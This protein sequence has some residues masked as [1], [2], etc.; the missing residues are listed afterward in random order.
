MSFGNVGVV[1]S[2]SRCTVDEP[3]LAHRLTTAESKSYSQRITPTLSG[4]Q[5]GHTIPAVRS[6]PVLG[7][8]F[9]GAILSILSPARRWRF[10]GDRQVSCVD[11]NDLLYLDADLDDDG[12][13]FQLVL[14]C[15]CVCCYGKRN[16]AAIPVAWPTLLSLSER[17]REVSGKKCTLQYAKPR[18]KKHVDVLPTSD[19]LGLL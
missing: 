5:L 12:D 15:K 8:M 11:H 9:S 4:S 18:I 19:L 10:A 7:V 17:R 14:I 6:P 2:L 16:A 1:R 3:M 13:A